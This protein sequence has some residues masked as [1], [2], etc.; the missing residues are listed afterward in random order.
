MV[1]NDINKAKLTDIQERLRA[2][3][4]ELKSLKSELFQEKYSKI[5]KEISS[6]ISACGRAEN[7]L[8]DLKPMEGQIDIFSMMEECERD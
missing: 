1:I 8:N 5:R 3:R 4:N 6:A 2:C 7:E